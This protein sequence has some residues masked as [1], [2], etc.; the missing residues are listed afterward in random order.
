MITNL[1]SA[2]LSS[3]TGPAFSLQP[4]QPEPTLTDFDLC[5][6]PYSRNVALICRY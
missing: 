5:S 2:A 6:Q 3:Q 4:Q 1:P